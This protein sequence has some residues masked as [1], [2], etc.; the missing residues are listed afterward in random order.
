MLTSGIVQA[1]CITELLPEAALERANYL[2]S[3]LLQEKKPIGPL[4]GLPISVKEH[5]AMKGLTCNAGFIA[6]SKNVPDD[7]ATILKLLWNAGA[8]FY[9]RTTQPQTLMHLETS[10]NFYGDT[11]N[12]FNRSLTCGGSSGG[13][14]ALIGLRGSCL[15]IGTD[16]GGSFRSPAANNGLYGFR[17]TTYRLPTAGLISSSRGREQIIGV[18]GPLSTSLEG[19]KLFMK[20]LIDQKPWNYQQSLVP[21]P[22]RISQQKKPSPEKKLKVAVMWDDGVVRPHPPITRA[23]KE[24][25]EKLKSVSAVEIVD[26]KPYKHDR[27]WE[28]I[29]SLYWP[30]AGADAREIMQKSGEP[31]RPLTDFII[32]DNPFAVKA[33]PIAEV[34][35]LTFEREKYKEEYLQHWNNTASG[36]DE[37][38]DLIDAVDVILCP[39]GPG[40]APPLNH[41]KYWGYTSQWNLLDY[42]SL[43]FPVTKVDQTKD[44]VEKDYQPKN[45]QDEFNYELCK[46]SLQESWSAGLG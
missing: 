11:V 19:V 30:D 5:V 21:L 14:G 41:S 6:W 4:H 17:P 24:I 12:P 23:M 39:V 28:I 33:R 45:E 15:G 7:D 9:A 44:V 3:Y 32:T 29:S 18:I 36:R 38:G 16:I 37:T 34:W 27:A 46:A 2:D 1:N 43:V 25:A 42:P 22:W 13:E 31:R 35:D 40:A 8:V 20:S 10:S 26:W